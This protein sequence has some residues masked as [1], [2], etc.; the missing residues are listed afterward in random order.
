MKQ[1]NKTLYIAILALILA[2]YYLVW[3]I[4]LAKL[5]YFNKEEL[6]LIE[7][8]KI[9]F[10]GIGNRLKVMGLTSPLLPFYGTFIF[11]TISYTVAPIMASAFGTGILFYLI[12]ST[13]LK[14]TGDEFYILVILLLFLF[15]PG[16][17]YVG[18]SGKSIYMV[19]I[20]FYLFYLNIFKFYN[21]NTTFHVSI[22]SICLVIL[23][24]CDYKFV[25]LTLFFIPLVLSISIHTL[26]LGEKE[27]IFRLF[28]SFN[29]PSLR[30]KLISKSMAIFVI[31]FILPLASVLIYKMLNLTHANDL[32]YFIDSPYSNWSV[33]AEKIDYST[34]QDT[35]THKLPEISILV[36]ARVV[37][38]FPLILLAFYLFRD[39]TYQMLTLLTPFFFIEFLKI[40]YAKVFIPQQYYIIFLILALLCIVTKIRTVRNEGVFKVT[41]IIMVALSV[42]TGYAII[43]TSAI[44]EER[45]FISSLLHKKVIDSQEEVKSVANY[46]NNLPETSHVLLDDAIAYPIASFSRDIRSLTLPYQDE[47]LSAIEAPQKYDRYV[48]IASNKN[49]A[50]SYT[51]LNLKYVTLYKSANSNVSLRKVFETENWILYQIL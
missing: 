44:S 7:K 30:R 20:F 12:C 37:I 13:L 45:N 40:K 26:N 21:S 38:F 8:A 39:N 36:S 5:G 24:F 3:G 28:L 25:W 31:L 11:T 47:Y 50:N 2:V 34:L 23:I 41:L 32:N 14:R 4:Y 9:V 33:L 49:D 29:N 22:S 48:L 46:I 15:H 27:S 42:Y 18:S 35:V 10:E 17:L 1:Q 16:L 19:L 43:N 51:E 6:F